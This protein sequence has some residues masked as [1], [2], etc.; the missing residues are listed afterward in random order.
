MSDLKLEAK[1]ALNLDQPVE[2]HWA[3][4]SFVEITGENYWWL[5]ASRGGEEKLSRRCEKHLGAALPEPGSFSR[6][7]SGGASVDLLWAGERQ[8]MIAGALPDLPSSTGKAGYLTDQSDGWVAFTVSGSKTRNVLEKLCQLDLHPASFPDGAC[9]RMAVEGMIAIIA[10]EDS[11]EPRYRLML[12][13]S[14][15]RSM[16]GH[17]RHAAFSTCGEK[18]EAPSAPA[19]V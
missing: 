15:A 16:A 2:E 14:S 6:G 7:K 9:A 19:A 11:D 18:I 8:W 1:T 17:I 10:C 3:G 12:Q 5:A 4:F 13:R